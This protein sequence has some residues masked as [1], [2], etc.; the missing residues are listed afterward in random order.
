MPRDAELTAALSRFDAL[1]AVTVDELV[2]RWRGTEIPTG[3]P[4]GVVDV[5]YTSRPYVLILHRE[6]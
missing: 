5:R 3:H 6:D 4:L 1:P 2:G